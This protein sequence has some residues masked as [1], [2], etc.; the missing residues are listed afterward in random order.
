MHYA[1]DTGQTVPLKGKLFLAPQTSE[2]C[3][4]SPHQVLGGSSLVVY[5]TVIPSDS[6]LCPLHS[7][8]AHS[9]GS[10]TAYEYIFN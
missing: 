1:Q 7:R 6:S 9:T 5:P 4:V 10:C 8:G 3:T 2:K